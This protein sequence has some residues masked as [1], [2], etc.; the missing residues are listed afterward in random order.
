MAVLFDS[1]IDRFVTE[2]PV[3]VMV[4]G[5]M[6]NVLSTAEVDGV[7][8]DHAERQYEDELLFSSV[9]EVLG[10]LVAAHPGVSTNDL[11]TYSMASEFEETH[12][13]LDIAFSP[14]GW[15]KRFARLRPTKMADGLLAIARFSDPRKYKKSVRGPKTPPVRR[16]GTSHKHRAP[17]GE[18]RKT[19]NPKV[20]ALKG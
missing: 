5:A 14:E 6:A 20:T 4:R 16:K 2:A 11:S 18:S 3:A 17:L 9:V 1:L 10:W 19:Q 7:F 12:R 13:G 8:R 15:L